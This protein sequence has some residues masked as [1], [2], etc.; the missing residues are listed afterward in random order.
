MSEPLTRNVVLLVRVLTTRSYT[1]A[2]R[3]VKVLVQQESDGSFAVT[4]NTTLDHPVRDLCEMDR[5][6]VHLSR[7][8]PTPPE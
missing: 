4:I 6:L 1:I 7:G 5:M 8:S 2:E 3:E